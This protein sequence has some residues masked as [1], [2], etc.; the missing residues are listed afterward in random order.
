MN[1]AYSSIISRSPDTGDFLF[2]RRPEIPITISGSAGTARYVALVDSGSDNTIFPKSVAD[3]LQI[4]L[5]ATSGPDATLF[6]GRHV[7]LLTGEE[8]L[9]LDAD[10]ESLEWPAIICFFDF[11]TD[12]EETVLLGHAGFLDYF[13]ATLDGKQGVLTLIA[14]DELPSRL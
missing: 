13:T 1:F 2:I 14:N 8:I 5:E 4:P 6:G 9:Q 3:Y 11:P 10:G 7:Q 12:S